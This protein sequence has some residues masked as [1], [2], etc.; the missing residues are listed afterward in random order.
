VKPARPSADLRISTIRAS[1][2]ITNR[3]IPCLGRHVDRV[4]PTGARP[5]Y[6][7]FKRRRERLLQ[8][9]LQRLL[10]AV[11]PPIKLP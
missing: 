6:G 11:R 2:S 7:S 8:R 10:H 3:R 1:S 9:L 4:P 5:V